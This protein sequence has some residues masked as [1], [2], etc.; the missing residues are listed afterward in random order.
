MRAMT[1]PL[2]SNQSLPPFAAIEAAHVEPAVRE[3]LD[4]NRAAIA[5]LLDAGA[6]GWDSL[7]V[8]IERMHH[9]LA[10]VWSP[11]SHLNGVMNSEALRAAYNACLPLLTAYHTEL[12][13]NER[14]CAAYQRVADREGAALA[15]EQRK[16]VENALRDFRLAGVSLPPERKQRFGAVMERLATAQAKFDENVLDATHA[17][18]RHVT[19]GAELE[20]L[21]ANAVERAR[22]AAT[23]G[24]KDG[25]LLSLDAPTY[26]A[27][28]SHAVSEPLRRELYEAW[29]TRASD[30]GPHAGQWDN[31]P[32]MAE[33]LALRHEAANLVGF[34][35]FAEYS[36]ATKMARDPAEV[37]EFLLELARVSKPAAEREFAELERFAGRPLASWDVAFYSERMRKERLQVSEE[38]LRPYFPLPRVLAGLFTVVHRLYGVRIVANPSVETYHPDVRFFDVLDRD[39]TPRGGFFLDLYAR[40][41]KRGGAWMDE[42]VG[43]IRLAGTSALPIAYLVCNFSP[44]SGDQPSLLTH[45]EVLTLFHEFGHG[46]HHLLTRVDV[47]SVAGIN[48]V[49][50]D[51]VE[52][53]SQFMEN[54]AWRDEVLPLVSA[55]VETGEALPHD[56]LA[57]LQASRTFQAGMQTVR[58]LEFAL[59]DFKLHAGYAPAA[60]RIAETLAEVREAVSVLRPPEF[61]RFPHSFQHVFSGGYAAGYYSYKWAEVLSAD[62]FGAFEEHGVF[63]TATAHRFLTAILERGGSRDAMEAFVEFRGRKPEIEPLLR[64]M[65]LAA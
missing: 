24:G 18:S 44:P 30:R 51:A 4:E 15:P 22:A 40:P 8:P 61:N 16:V 33:I 58:Q 9:R 37:L 49:P 56:L 50:W 12:G 26:Q 5:A 21:P 34:A 10:R 53:P 64:Q 11:V 2:L 28:L 31:G 60:P 29:V 47:P 7:V 59:F 48:G 32:L 55:H 52:L 41:K 45:S 19:D 54:F 39:D 17:W 62:A 38:A 6:D 42:C 46:L 13:Q 27:V 36:L 63:D 43:R 14:L 3:L 1:N 65:G 57:R 35:N 25:W 23:A 20:G